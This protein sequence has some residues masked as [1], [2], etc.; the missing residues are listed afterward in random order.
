MCKKNHNNEEPT[1][2]L[3]CIVSFSKKVFAKFLYC[4]KDIFTSY[5]LVS[6]SEN[7]YRCNFVERQYLLESAITVLYILR[8]VIFNLNILSNIF[9][10][11]QKIMY[12][13]TGYAMLIQCRI[14]RKN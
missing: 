1:L 4:I 12:L 8:L 3:S 5:L 9:N 6:I 2:R 13:R 14:K 7:N 11:Y 10:L